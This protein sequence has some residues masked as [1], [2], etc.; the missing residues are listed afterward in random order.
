MQLGRS[1]KCGGSENLA[2]AILNSMLLWTFSS[3]GLIVNR[4]NEDY[5]IPEDELLDMLEEAC[6]FD[7]RFFTNLFGISL[8]LAVGTV[9]RNGF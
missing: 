6:I 7:V 9:E 4:F 8:V 2:Q 5:N 1:W 3:G